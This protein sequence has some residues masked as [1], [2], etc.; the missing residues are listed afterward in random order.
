MIKYL[1][2]RI[3]PRLPQ[4]SHPSPAVFWRLFVNGTYAGQVRSDLAQ[5]I[6]SAILLAAPTSN[7]WVGP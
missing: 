6:R 4:Q 2:A 1:P 7:V 5:W 3:Y